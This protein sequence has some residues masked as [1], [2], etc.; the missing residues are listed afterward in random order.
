MNKKL[1]GIIVGRFGTQCEAAQVLG[2]SEPRLSRIIR[3]WAI[4]G[5]QARE[6]LSR[7]FGE[8]ILKSVLNAN[9][10]TPAKQEKLQTQL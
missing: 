3:G 7:A 4:P 9:G 8:Q 10:E 6:A 5:D 2:L 1:K